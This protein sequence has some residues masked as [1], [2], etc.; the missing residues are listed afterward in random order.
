MNILITGSNGFVAKNLIFYL[1]KNENKF[2]LLKF[3]K[4]NNFNDLKKKIFKSDIIFHLAG[5]NKDKKK[6][7]FTKNNYELTKKIC[8]FIEE[9]KKKIPL[10]FSSTKHVYLE[11]DYGISKKKSEEVIKKF[12]KKN[13]PCVIYRLPGIFGKWCKPNYN[14]V[15]AT[16]CNNI[17]FNKKVNII[18]PKK[19]IELCYIDD[20]VKSFEK[21]IYLKQGSKK[22]LIINKFRKSYF[23]SIKNLYKKI[24]Y[25]NK[26]KDSL[27]IDKIG[28][29]FDKLL[30]ATFLSYL[31]PNLFSSNYLMPKKDKRGLFVEACKSKTHGQFSF[32]TLKPGQIR[33]NHYH[34]TK[35]EKFFIIKGSALFKF[36]NIVTKKKFSLKISSN[37]FKTIVSIPGWSHSIKNIGNSELIG[38]VWANE[39]F[40]ISKPDTQKYN[41]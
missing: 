32:F 6:K 36:C 35:I 28:K 2:K 23:I 41:L 17:I 26:T 33:G 29:G 7:F 3:S 21:H 34:N 19:I 13:N 31:P 5:T 1:K 9:S 22:L 25:F 15:V 37:S 11:T 8:Q 4:K 20:V 24:L 40:D 12:S 27:F 10:I 39:V 16:F 30:Y 38:N 18:D 14:S